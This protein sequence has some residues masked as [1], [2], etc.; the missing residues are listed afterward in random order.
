MSLIIQSV[1]VFPPLANTNGQGLAALCNY[2]LVRSFTSVPAFA[3][4]MV[5]QVG[6]ASASPVIVTRS[7]NPAL[8]HHHQ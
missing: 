5:I 8:N 4:S 2:T 6:E 3:L 1:K 7:A